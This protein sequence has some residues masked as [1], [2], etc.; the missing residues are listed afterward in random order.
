MANLL[1][2]D[3]A[4][5]SVLLVEGDPEALDENPAAGQRRLAVGADHLLYLVD[6][7]GTATPV[8]ASSGMTD[9]MTTR[10]DMIYRDSS[11]VTARLPIPAAGQVVGRVGSDIGA[12]YPPGY[13]FDYVEITSSGT[14]TATSEATATA[15]ITG[16]AVTY[17]G[18]TRIK[19]EAWF[20]RVTPASGAVHNANS[21][22][23]D[24]SS[25]IGLFSLPS[26]D[27]AVLVRNAP[28]YLVR[29]LTPS[30]AAHT[31]SIRGFVDS[32]TGTWVA[33]AGGSGNGMPAWMR[34][35]K[36]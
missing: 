13:E 23:Y 21:V 2:H 24:G 26:Y 31:Y 1:A 35:T 9:P 3:N 28:T 14:S 27:P 29:Y 20:A 19:I 25:S 11:N 8:G 36:A 10:G 15:I 34:I 18:S 32:G 30:A 33:A 17:D 5:P 16:A 12:L 22:L 6:D 7:A 4:F